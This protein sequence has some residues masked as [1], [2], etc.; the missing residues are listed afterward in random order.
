MGQIFFP[1]KRAAQ[2]SFYS[3]KKKKISRKEIR[4]KR[5]NGLFNL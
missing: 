3:S 1:G 2:P 4:R 5:E